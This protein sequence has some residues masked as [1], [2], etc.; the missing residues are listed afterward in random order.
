MTKSDLMT[1]E[2]EV[3]AYIKNRINDISMIIGNL[4]IPALENAGF[5]KEYLTT[6]LSS[7][8]VKNFISTFQGN[9]E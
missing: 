7:S 4:I 1:N 9:K 3:G 5:S 6:L 2:Y 8:E